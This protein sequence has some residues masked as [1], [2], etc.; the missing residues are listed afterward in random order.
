M[1]KKSKNIVPPTNDGI[2][3]PEWATCLVGKLSFCPKCKQETLLSDGIKEVCT[4]CDYQ[5][6]SE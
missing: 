5:K 3:N 2:E 6:F 1:D 4:N